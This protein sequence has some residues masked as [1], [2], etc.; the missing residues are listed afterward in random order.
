MASDVVV[1]AHFHVFENGEVGGSF[2]NRRVTR[3][4]MQSR[5]SCGG[6]TPVPEDH[7]GGH[8]SRGQQW[9]GLGRGL[10]MELGGFRT[11]RLLPREGWLGR[12]VWTQA[13]VRHCDTPKPPGRWH[14]PP[15]RARSKWAGRTRAPA[16]ALRVQAS[17]TRAAG[18]TGP[19]QGSG[20]VAPAEGT[21]QSPARRPG[22]GARQEGAAGTHR[23]AGLQPRAKG[24]R[25]GI[26]VR[27]PW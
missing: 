18:H 13:A 25:G 21:D 14:V 10:C 15:L 27:P 16:S 1:S 7:S 4:E 19:Q 24:T 2:W 5:E 20:T 12:G 17:R 22:P 23:D 6:E 9:P 3:C 11:P 8:D 26:G